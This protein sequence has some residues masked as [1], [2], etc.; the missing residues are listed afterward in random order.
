MLDEDTIHCFVD[1]VLFERFRDEVCADLYPKTGQSAIYPVL[2]SFVL[3]LKALAR[4]SNRQAAI[5]V[6]YR[7]DWK[8][9]LHLPPDSFYRLVRDVIDP[10]LH[11][12]QFADLYTGS[13]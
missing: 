13:E 10:D 3:I 8:Y 11:D 7:L 2:L 4:C 6:R 9:A 5:T 1:D 12:D